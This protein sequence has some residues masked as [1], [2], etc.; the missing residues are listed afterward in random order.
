VSYGDIGQYQKALEEFLEVQQLAPDDA[1]S[2]FNLGWV[3]LCLNRFAES[4]AIYSQALAKNFDV[5]TVHER[6]YLIA[7]V[8]GDTEAMRRHA[9]WAVGNPEEYG[10]LSLQAATEAYFGK[11]RKA[12]DLWRRAAELAEHAG[13]KENAAAITA[14]EALI[15][16]SYGNL[17]QARDQTAK[18]MALARTRDVMW[19]EAAAL[20]V[21]GDVTKGEAFAQDSARQFPKDTLV[22][23]VYV[24]FLQAGLELQRGD[25]AQAIEAL[26]AAIP[27]ER[28]FW[29]VLFLRGQAYLKA[30]AGSEAAAQFQ[31]M[32]EYR[33][34]LRVNHPWQALAHLYLGRAWAMAGDKGKSRLAYEDFLALWKNA[35]PDIPIFQQAKA[36]YAKLQ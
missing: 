8:E 6:L 24:P 3:Y 20:G 15:E 10:M 31:R 14:Y 35:D 26:Q 2:Y 5:F 13:L 11:L 30:G 7:F 25:S 32:M 1:Y 21:S 4:K 12:R 27:Y 23:A 16:A 34:G 17:P 19:A 28:A 36:E 9:A 22:H 33:G 18:A 29:Q